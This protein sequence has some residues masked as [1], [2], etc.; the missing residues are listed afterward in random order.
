MTDEA[1]VGYVKF[2]YNNTPDWNKTGE[3]AANEDYYKPVKTGDDSNMFI[4]AVVLIFSLLS[5]ITL[6]FSR[7]KAGKVVA[8]GLGLIV[9]AMAGLG[10]FATNVVAAEDFTKEAT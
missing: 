2:S 10:F 1:I 6:A 9:I 8:K 7:K 3:I 5:L 4:Y